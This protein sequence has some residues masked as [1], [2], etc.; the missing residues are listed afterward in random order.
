MAMTTVTLGR[1]GITVQKN[2]FGALPI[3]R[4]DTDY[5][6]KL[7]RKAYEAGITYFDSARAYTDSEEKIGLALSDV[8]SKIFIATKTMSTTVEGFWEQLHE[9]LKLLKTDYIDVYQF[10]NPAFCPKPNDGS[11]LYEA[12]QEAKQ[13][14][15]IRFIGLT[16]HRL[17]VAE[18]AVESG[19]YDVLQFP[20]C[21]LASDRDIALVKR[22][23]EQNVGFV[24]MKGLSGGLLTNSAAC[25]AWQAAFDNALP[26][27]G[28]QREQELD[29][30]LRYIDNP[31][32]MDDP[33]IKAVIDKDRAELIGNF[34]RACG[35]CMPCPVGITINQCARMSQLIRRSPS[36]VL[37]NEENQAMM[38]KI[39]DCVGCGRCKARC[40]YGLDI[41]NL[42]KK[43]LADYED[44]LA[45]KVKL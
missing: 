7:L 2:G 8:R 38:R 21:Y 26:I 44:I 11:G 35:Y 37:M 28:V 9:S 33:E 23:K 30:F 4:V 45:G 31:P 18:E 10:H 41:P 5:A 15:K 16:N 36:A 40:P 27:W 14:G 42:L 24:S 1:T 3:Q 39:N 12:M 22:C 20:F 19:L 43:N 17:S 29:E 13:Q 32:S 25:Y 34:C 6:G